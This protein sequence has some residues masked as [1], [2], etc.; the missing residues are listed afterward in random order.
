MFLFIRSIS[1]AMPQSYFHVQDE[2]SLPGVLPDAHALLCLLPPPDLPCS[3]LL[4]VVRGTRRFDAD[5]PLIVEG[6]VSRD[7]FF[8]FF[9]ESSSPN[10]A[11][12]SFLIFLKNWWRYSQVQVHHR[13]QRHRWQICSRHQQHWWQ[14]CIGV[15]DDGGKKWEWYL[16][17]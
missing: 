4:E 16:K 9:H 13:Y 1:S 15:K 6:T 3:R 5:F 17:Y 10:I 14:I 8:M 7:F 11:L 2:R 12:G